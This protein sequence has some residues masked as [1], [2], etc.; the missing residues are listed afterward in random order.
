MFGC[1]HRP[2]GD[3]FRE[4]AAIADLEHACRELERDTGT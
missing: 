4:P 3:A 2:R 1:S